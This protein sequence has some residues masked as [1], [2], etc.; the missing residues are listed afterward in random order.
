MLEGHNNGVDSNTMS[1]CIEDEPGEESGSSVES[2]CG[3]S[4]VITLEV[5]KR[6]A[7]LKSY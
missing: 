1:G 5:V 2:T 3:V 4:I 7:M 6:D